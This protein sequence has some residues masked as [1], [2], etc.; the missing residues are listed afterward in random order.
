M[1]P[2]TTPPSLPAWRSPAIS[3]LPRRET[4]L[5]TCE[6]GTSALGLYTTSGA[7]LNA[8]LTTIS[9]G[10]VY[11]ESAVQVGNTI[12]AAVENSA[13]VPAYGLSG[14]NV[15]TT[16]S[17]FITALTRFPGSIV[18]DGTNYYIN[19]TLLGHL[20]KFDASG[21]SVNE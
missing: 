20:Q 13:A 9:G 1:A 16:N 6:A 7:T 21:N 2:P 12:V 14:N 5:V 18:T 8:T 10:G 4:L 19:D 17:A 11:F 15:V 3:K